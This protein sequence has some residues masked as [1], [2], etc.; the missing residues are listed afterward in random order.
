MADRRGKPTQ[1][2]GL[3]LLSFPLMT[4]QQLRAAIDERIRVQ[5]IDIYV[6]CFIKA[7]CNNKV[8]KSFLSD[9]C[10]GYIYRPHS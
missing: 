8:H 9:P 2:D 4:G 10:D 3:S 5:P 7:H 6:T 1:R